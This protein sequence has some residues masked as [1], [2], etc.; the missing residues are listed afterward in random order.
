LNFLSFSRS[1][2]FPFLHPIFFLKNFIKL[3]FPS[4]SLFR[5][6]WLLLF[7]AC[8]CLSTWQLIQLRL[9]FVHLPRISVSFQALP[10][11]FQTELFIWKGLR[12]LFLWIAMRFLLDYLFL[13]AYLWDLWITLHI[14]WCF[15][16][17]RQVLFSFDRDPERLPLILNLI[18]LNVL[19]SHP[20]TV[21]SIFFELRFISFALLL[22]F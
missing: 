7:T 6:D 2:S 9:A 21:L 5:G 20:S 3:L 16:S 22:D 11:S 18:Y 10:W 17:L 15:L 12:F 19:K 14:P 4:R 1:L 13:R 8:I